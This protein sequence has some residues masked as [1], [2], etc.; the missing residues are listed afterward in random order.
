[1]IRFNVTRA[2]LLLA[3]LPLVASPALVVALPAGAAATGCSASYTVSSQWQ[4]G[5]NADVSITNLGDP[6]TGGTLTWSFGA[7]QS[8]TQAW[9]ATVTQSG[10]A[11]T[12]KNVDY[13]CF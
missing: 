4:G 13:F 5:V 3:G 2:G 6:L 7:G 9:N 1:M 11:A 8:V 10:S 12:A